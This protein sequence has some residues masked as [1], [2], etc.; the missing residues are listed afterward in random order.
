MAASVKREEF[1]LI[2]PLT[3]PEFIEL[4]NSVY[5]KDE[6]DS[7]DNNKVITVGLVAGNNTVN[8]GLGQYARAVYFLRDGKNDVDFTWM[9]DELDPDNKIVILD[10]DDAEDIELL[11]KTEGDGSKFY[12]EELEL[13]VGDN[14]ITHGKGIPAYAVT[15]LSSGKNDVDY[16]WKR[17]PADPNNKIIILGVDDVETIEVNIQL[18]QA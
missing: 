7:L 16:L 2:W 11:I 18:E 17:D 15:L 1:K 8:H 4:L 9:R 14:T 13:Q 6:V 10:V 5:F 12:T 3:Q